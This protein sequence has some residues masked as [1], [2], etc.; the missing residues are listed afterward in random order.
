[1]LQHRSAGL[2][3]IKHSELIGLLATTYL[4]LIGLL[5]I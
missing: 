1:M 5:N 2:L 4:E 3:D